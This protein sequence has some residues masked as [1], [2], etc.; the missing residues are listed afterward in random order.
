MFHLRQYARYFDTGS[1]SANDDDIHQCLLFFWIGA[2]RRFL[3]IG[4]KRVTQDK[5]FFDG[6]HRQCPAL[7]HFVAEEVRDCAGSYYQVIIFQFSDRG[8][9]QVLFPHDRFHFGQPEIEVFPLLEYL[10]EREGDGTRFESGRGYLI[11]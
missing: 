10:T 8:Q 7:D 11:E 3:E 4:E 5:G 1:T 2:D 9:Y 6:F